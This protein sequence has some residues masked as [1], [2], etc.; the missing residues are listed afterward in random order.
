MKVIVTD[1]ASSNFLMYSMLGS[2][3]YVY[4]PLYA[5]DDYNDKLQRLNET[6]CPDVYATGAGT[7]SVQP[8]HLDDQK[9][10]NS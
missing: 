4:N 2:E 1:F 5:R 6:S 7:I 9:S 3:P 10:D 8:Y